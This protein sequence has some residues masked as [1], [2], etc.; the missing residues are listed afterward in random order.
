MHICCTLNAFYANKRDFI[1]D[2]F[3]PHLQMFF[4][5]FCQHFLRF[6]WEHHCDLVYDVNYSGDNDIDTV[7][8]RTYD[9]TPSR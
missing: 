3:I 5:K 6:T 4:L 9:T 8:R 2:V 7:L 1:I